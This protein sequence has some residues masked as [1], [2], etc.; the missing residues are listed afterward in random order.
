M[1][2]ARRYGMRG[3]GCERGRGIAHIE[4]PDHAQ[5]HGKCIAIK[6]FGRLAIK[7]R[8][9]EKVLQDSTADVTPSG[10]FP[11]RIEGQPHPFVNEVID[12]RVGRSGIKRQYR[13]ARF[14]GPCMS[15]QS[16]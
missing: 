11:V 2:E 13:R 8:I 4:V 6:G 14:G 5:E 7:I 10:Q 12:R 15:G 1:S 9:S 3:A 16:S